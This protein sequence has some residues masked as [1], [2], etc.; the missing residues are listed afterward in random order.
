MDKC[1][2]LELK[3]FDT[4]IQLSAENWK[5]GITKIKVGGQDQIPFLLPALSGHHFFTGIWPRPPNAIEYEPHECPGYLVRLSETESCYHQPTTPYSKVE[6]KIEYALV[7]RGTV[8]ITFET[9]SHA[10][11]YPYGYVGLFRGTVVRE[12]GQRGFHILV[13]N[14]DSGLT[15]SY[16]AGSG[17][18]SVPDRNTV[19]GPE[20]PA[21]E[22]NSKHPLCYF[23][24]Q[25]GIR[26][27]LPIQIGRW[28]NL[29]MI[30]EVDDLTV[31]FTDVLMATAVGGPSW[32]IYWCLKPGETRK[33]RCRLTV[34]QWRGWQYVEQRYRQWDGC[35]D[36]GFRVSGHGQD[37]LQNFA[38][39]AASELTS[40][41]GLLLSRRLFEERGKSLLE[42]LGLLDKCSAACL[43]GTS[44]NAGLDDQWSRDHI[45][46]PYLTFVLDKDNFEKY[47]EMLGKAL[48]DLPDEVDGVEWR[49]Y[50]GAQPRRTAVVEMDAFMFLLTGVRSKPYLDR[51]WI[52]LLSRS[53]FLGRRW[54]E[55]MFDATQGEIFHD[56][57]RQLTG[58]WRHRTGYVPPD[59]HRA[60]LARSLF[61]VWN[62]GPEYNL[63]RARARKDTLAYG[64]CLD[65]FVNEVIELS[66]CWNERYPPQFKWRAEQLRRLPM[67]PIDIVDGLKAIAEAE[68]EAASF[69]K[70]ERVVL[71]VKRVMT[72]LYH[73]N[74]DKNELLSRFAREMHDQIDDEE[75][76]AATELD[77]RPCV[78]P[79]CEMHLTFPALPG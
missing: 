31:A 23:F 20:M 1:L 67:V 26:F 13:K 56:P 75:L 55:Q 71:S 69:E 73:L 29:A 57:G 78:A 17:D 21:P 9:I 50:G 35:V 74:A 22:H 10:D 49:G 66:F 48:A 58:L 44:Q 12:G 52:P 14:G 15:W 28:Q 5:Q 46:G 2:S 62:A 79:P 42:K 4:Q 70:A 38:K 59:V 27:A 43:G 54:I 25:S 39:P 77:W 61:R 7:S 11:K 40:E 24:A 16:F 32:D 19:L 51:E 3:G 36:P 8:E 47:G 63:L 45:W 18:S 6:T 41:S 72:D 76:K 33:I 34:D 65:R 60:L 64:L 53:S 37:T 68:G 30:L